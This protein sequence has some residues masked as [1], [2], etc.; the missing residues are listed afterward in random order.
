MMHRRE[1]DFSNSKYWFRQA[2]SLPSRLGLDP[3]AL[4]DEVARH[5]RENPAHL[6]EAQ[7]REWQILF[8][9]CARQIV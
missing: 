4:T 9:H 6:V 8:L 7:R 2:G 3:F 5:H 1:G